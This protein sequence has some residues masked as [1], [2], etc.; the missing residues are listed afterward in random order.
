MTTRHIFT[1][2]RARAYFLI[3]RLWSSESSNYFTG[4]Y[5]YIRARCKVFVFRR[6]EGRERVSRLV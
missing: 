3:M 2:A 5:K 1:F 4:L 6:K